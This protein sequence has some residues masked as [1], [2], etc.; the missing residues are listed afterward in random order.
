[1]ASL[2]ASRDGS[3]AGP[4]LQA[5]EYKEPAA[6]VIVSIIL[7]LVSLTILS[8]FISPCR[9]CP[10]H[11]EKLVLISSISDSPENLV[12]QDLESVALCWMA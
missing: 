2:L 5:S 9:P 8:L 3:S 10:E 6:G 7:T 4:Q 12:H 11:L 1:M